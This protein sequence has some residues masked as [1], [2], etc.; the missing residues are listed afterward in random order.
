[1]YAKVKLGVEG[2]DIVLEAGN[3]LQWAIPSYE[4]RG[5]LVAV[6]NPVDEA[7]RKSPSRF[8]Q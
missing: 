8:F 3:L 4:L 6:F 7:M 2:T 1:M 5:L